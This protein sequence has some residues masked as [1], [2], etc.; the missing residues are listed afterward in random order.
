MYKFNFVFVVFVH[1]EKIIMCILL[2]RDDD[3]ICF[4]TIYFSVG[5]R[6]RIL[7]RLENV[8]HIQRVEILV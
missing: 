5:F 3:F 4:K 8:S 1:K 7:F 2:H 6:R